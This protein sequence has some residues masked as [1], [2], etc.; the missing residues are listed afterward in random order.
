MADERVH[1]LSLDLEDE[2]PP[3]EHSAPSDTTRDAELRARVQGRTD[4]LLARAR[5]RWSR[6]ALPRPRIRYRLRGHS[7]GEACEATGSTNYNLELLR[8][9]GDD[10][11][12]RI[13]PHEVAHYVVFQVYGRRAQPHGREWREVMSLFGVPPD[14]RHPYTTRPARRLLRHRYGCLCADVHLLT[15]RAHRAIRRGRA[16]YRCRKC[17]A[18]LVPLG[19][20]VR[21]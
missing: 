20:R 5:V 12:A 21:A 9:H 11:I 14:V 6:H 4:E 2:R 19:G 7:A 17:R 13:V 16:E 15:E 18:A 3:A 1:Q 10:F 8:R